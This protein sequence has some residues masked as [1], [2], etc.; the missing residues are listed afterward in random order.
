MVDAG[1]RMLVRV[2]IRE[3]PVSVLGRLHDSVRGKKTGSR[4][5]SETVSFVEEEKG[6][7]LVAVQLVKENSALV[8][9]VWLLMVKMY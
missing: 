3:G 8:R 4:V 9:S 5:R 6:S 1:F 7:V 2:R